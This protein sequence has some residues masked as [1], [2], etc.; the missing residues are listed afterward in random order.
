MSYVIKCWGKYA[1]FGSYRSMALVER[2]ENATVYARLNDA[3][4]RKKHTNYL[5]GN[6]E[7]PIEEMEIYEVTF[8]YTE[9]RS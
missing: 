9:K 3:E 2:P 5:N 8:T 7:I 6:E 4:K 1:R